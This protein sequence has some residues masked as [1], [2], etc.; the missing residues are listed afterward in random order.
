MTQLEYTYMPNFN[1]SSKEVV[2]IKY[3]LSYIVSCKFFK[4]NKQF[5][6]YVDHSGHI[7]IEIDCMQ[8]CSDEI[9]CLQLYITLHS[10]VDLG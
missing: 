2:Q 7:L 3:I 5:V 8:R 9:I 6:Q 1:S 4:T 10:G